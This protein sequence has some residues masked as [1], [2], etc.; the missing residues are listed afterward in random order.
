MTEHISAYLKEIN[1]LY[2]TGLTTEHSFR[3]ALQRLLTSCT[4]CK[5]VNEPSHIACGAPDLILLSKELPIAY[6]EA[7]D[8]EDG[9]LDGRHKNKEQF[10][11]YKASLDTIIFTD[12]LDFHLYEHG[13]WQ[14]SARLAEIQGNKIRLSDSERFISLME[15]LKSAKP[16][17][18]TS[19]SKLAQIM[20]GKARLLRDIIEQA[21]IQDGAVGDRDSYAQTELTS[22]MNAF[23]Q[24]LIHDITPKTFAD[25][26][27]QTIAYGMFAARLHDESPENFTRAEA[28]NLIPK[29]NPFLRKVFQQIAGYDLDER[30]AWI[31]D[32]LVNA[33]AATEMEKIMQGFGKN[34][35]QTDPIL[36]FYEDFLY[37]YDPAAK[38]Q[39]GVYYTPQPVVEFIVRAVDDLLRSEFN[40]PMGLADTTKVEV[41]QEREQDNKHRQDKVL[42]HRVQVLDPATGTGTFLVETVRQIKRDLGDQI[43]A[44]NSYVPEHLLP[45]LHG[46]ELMMAPYTIA[47]L[48]LDLEINIPAQDR[49][50]VFLTNSL[51]EANPDANTL[52]G[53]Y[54]AEEANIASKIKK[55]SPVMIVMGNPPYSGVSQ[56]NGEW[57][58][59][60]M[61]DYKKEP[62]GVLPLKERKIWLNDDY[63]KFIRLGQYYVD[64]NKEGI[65]AYICNNGFLDNPTFRGMRW[66]LLNSFD[67]IYIINLHGNSKKNEVSPNGE[68]DENV[69]DIMVGTSINIFIKTGKKKKGELAEVYYTDLYGQRNSKY[70]YLSNNP[71]LSINLK[72]LNY[73]E[74]FFF[75]VPTDDEGRSKYEEGFRIDELMPSQT[76][77]FVTANDKLNISFTAEEQRRKI[78]DL[79]E[80]PEQE[81][82]K[83]Y[84]REKDAR[85]W[86]YL[87]AQNDARSFKNEVQ[88]VA[89]RPFDVRFTYYTGNSR[90]LYSSPQAG[91]MY[92]LKE[93]NLGFACIRINGRPEDTYFVVDNIMDK[94]ILSSKDNANV[95]PLY[96]YPEEGSFDTERKPNLDETIWKQINAACGKETTP[97]DIFD[98]IY[99]V[100]HS[101][102]YREK[103]KEFLKVDFPRIPYPKNADEFEHFRDCGHQLRELHLMHNVP[104]SEVKFPEDGSMLV[105]KIGYILSIAPECHSGRVYINDTQFFANVSE[106]AWNMYIGG[107]QPAQKWLKDR[108]G[109]KLEFDDIEHYRKIIAVLMETARIMKQIDDPN[110]Q[111]E[112]LKHKVQDLEHQLQAVQS[113]SEVKI[114]GSNV[115]FIDNSTNYNI[116]K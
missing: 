20:A 29:T 44:W 105:E 37:Q 114:V 64:R 93:P 110:A 30:I 13:E 32:D 19:A 103:Y 79:L 54:L 69:F 74:P 6:I 81:W 61:A 50:R 76:M 66:N 71:L 41:L 31:V 42:R 86:T 2:Q 47:H 90:G 108:K 67:R 48:K 104:A 49:L 16:Q 27:A 57:I 68:K 35:Q 10:D 51:E 62:G 45:R 23:R 94:T 112:E 24:V 65:L 113:A 77:G 36:H 63:C 73:S 96:L 111:V 9:D 34:T 4:G 83:K 72:K 92:H 100:L 70:E 101:P 14:L 95:F 75:F 109:R 17:R 46:F 28:A 25:I 60:L 26:Y 99:G 89:Y 88:K 106:E 33:F 43:G 12:Y 22:Y 98:Y 85:D 102:H 91:I 115:T 8:L 97:E 21:L 116:K 53:H 3:P 18:I 84:D 40:L 1:Q 82:R 11:R 107:Y 39:C 58:T 52:F 80:M 87:T 5:V 56:N 59:N 78:H 55:E 38:K 7:K 15:H